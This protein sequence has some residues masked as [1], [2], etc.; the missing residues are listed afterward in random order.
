MSLRDEIEAA[1]ALVLAVTRSSLH[2]GCTTGGET[3][4]QDGSELTR[5]QAADERK[6]R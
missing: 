4:D 5:C 3:P 6:T 2:N 1:T